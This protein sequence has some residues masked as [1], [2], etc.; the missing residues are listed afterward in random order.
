ME[1][2]SKLQATTEDLR[3]A[4]MSTPSLTSPD[5]LAPL[6][7]EAPTLP[8]FRQ[9][10][11]AQ[12]S[13]VF[14]SL[15]RLGVHERDLEDLTHDVFLV[16]HRKLVDYDPARPFKPWLLGICARVASD[17]R[18][19]A[20]HRREQ[21]LGAPEVADHAPS[22]DAQLAAGDAQALVI[23]ALDA[24]EDERRVLLVMVDLD[25]APVTEAARAL[26][27]PLNTAY[28]RLRL[29][30]KELEAAVRRLR[31]KRGER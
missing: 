16:V 5:R 28:S 31:A 14:H 3:A 29:A 10:F 24:V 23:A 11:D 26:S 21:M 18:K 1:R 17:Y 30:R 7:G 25:E 4:P 8:T 20:R 22:L 13:Y 27:I 19:L 15:R 12:H 2:L 6:P 9:V